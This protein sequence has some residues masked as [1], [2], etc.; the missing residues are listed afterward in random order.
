[1]VYVLIIFSSTTDASMF[2][3]ILSLEAQVDRPLSKHSVNKI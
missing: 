2:I 3:N 1:M